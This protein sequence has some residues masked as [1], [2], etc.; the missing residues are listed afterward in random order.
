MRSRRGGGPC[1]YHSW[2]EP[3][4]RTSTRAA[5][6]PPGGPILNLSRQ[7]GRPVSL[8]ELVDAPDTPRNPARCAGAIGSYPSRPVRSACRYRSIG[9]SLSP[10]RAAH[11]EGQEAEVLG[12]AKGC[13]S[14]GFASRGGAPARAAEPQTRPDHRGISAPRR[15]RRRV[16]EGS[17]CRAALASALPPSEGLTHVQADRL[18]VPTLRRR[19]SP[20][21][22]SMPLDHGCVRDV[23]R[24]S[25]GAAVHRK[26]GA[27][28]SPSSSRTPT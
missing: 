26:P 23:P 6:R 1:G 18:P 11:L 2:P 28:P 13:A 4:R 5:R 16:E 20:R 8:A 7:A 3:P 27:H 9:L 15:V 12:R 24:P 25:P 19:S 10:S 22:R 14:R 17:A 21:S